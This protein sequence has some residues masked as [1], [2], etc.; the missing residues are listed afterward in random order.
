MGGALMPRFKEIVVFVAAVFLFSCGGPETQAIKTFMN[1]V[2][3]GDDAARAA[4]STVDFPGDVGSWELVEIS[5]ETTV[6]CQL[7][8]LR[9]KLSSANQ[10]KEF[11][12]QKY[13]IFLDDNKQIH[14]QY[15]A[16]MEKNPDAELKGRLAEYKEE[17]DKMDQE[18]KHLEQLVKDINRDLERS[19]SA[20]G[21]S[22]MGATVTDNYD[23]DVGVVEAS[24][25]VD[26]KPYTFTLRKYNLVNKANQSRPRSRWIIADIKQ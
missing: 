19:R 20:A 1:A 14:Q 2:K 10:D 3:S 18:E 13:G 15:L 11:H 23:G 7:P 4:V 21:I 5:P 25:L 17:L 16:Q 9:K 12:A 22:L 6:P 26:D 8:E 24:V